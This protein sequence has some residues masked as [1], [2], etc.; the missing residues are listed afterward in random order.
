MKCAYYILYEA[1]I[2][3]QREIPKTLDC[4]VEC[5]GYKTAQECPSKIDVQHLI[6]FRQFHLDNRLEILPDKSKLKLK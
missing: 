2:H 1:L 6:G 3:E 5:N 4:C